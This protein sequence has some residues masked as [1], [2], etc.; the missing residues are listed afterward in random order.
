MEQITFF[1]VVSDKDREK[2]TP[3]VWSCLRT[4]ANFSNIYP[5]GSADY[6]PVTHEPRCVNL[7]FKSK[8]V[9][10]YWHTVCKNYKPKG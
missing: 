6:F 4:C 7:N 5:D 1:E 9:R 2:I 3:E 10:N 8:L